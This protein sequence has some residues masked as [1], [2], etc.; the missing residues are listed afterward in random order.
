LSSPDGSASRP[1]RR[2]LVKRFHALPASEERYGLAEGP[3]W[4]GDRKRVL[5]VDIN[6]GAVHT[7][8]LTSGRVIHDTVLHFPGT[9]GAV[10]SSHEGE[11]LVAGARGLHHVSAEGFVSPGRQ[12]LDE[13]APSR[14]NDGG[15]DPAGRFLVG[16]LALDGR[17]NEEVLIRVDHDGLITVLDGDLGMSNGLA[18]TPEGDRLYSIDTT[19]GIVWT[20]EYEA[21]TGAVGPRSQFLH[22]GGDNPDG[23]CADEHGNLWIAMWG[24]GQVRCY[25]PAGEFVAVVEVDAPNTTSVAFV[26]ATLDALLITTASEQLSD[27]QRACHPDS[28]RLFIAQVG[29]S[30]APVQHWAGTDRT[31]AAH[32]TT[33]STNGR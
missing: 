23:M 4:D 21:I 31:S 6:A 33:T 3:V 13:H 27:E 1:L 17:S 22:L 32:G 14:L 19:A 10:V 16:S 2:D 30:G 25:S 24:G 7:G 26:G 11:L 28:G 5:W 29:V 20:R 9:V 18:F 12:L 15:C 8:S